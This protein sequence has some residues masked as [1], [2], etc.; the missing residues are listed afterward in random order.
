MTTTNQSQAKE[1][2]WH[3]AFPAPRTTEPNSISSEDL[4]RRLQGGERGGKE[5]LL[6]DLRRNDHEGGTIHSSINIPAQ[7]L[8]PS[9]EALYSLVTA[10]RIPLVIFYCGSSQGRGTRAAGWLADLIAH[11]SKS[12]STPKS[13]STGDFVLESVILK[14]GIKGWVKGGAEYT[15]WM[16]GFD[17]SVWKT[18]S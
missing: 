5:F 11:K 7:T 3:A 15:K 1:E 13:E 18:A 14:G 10:A 2:P 17:E 6:I 12:T 8:Y 16:D 4:L 9:L